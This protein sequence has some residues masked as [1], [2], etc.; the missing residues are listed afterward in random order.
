MT[1][2]NQI[3]ASTVELDKILAASTAK[4]SEGRIRADLREI[5]R[6]NDE[7]EDNDKMFK[8]IEKA[9]DQQIEE[10][11]ELGWKQCLSVATNAQALCELLGKQKSRCDEAVATLEEIGKQLCLQLREQDEEYVN[12]LKRSRKEI[13]FLEECI[14]NEHKILKAAFERELGKVENAF[15]SERKELLET[16]QNELEALVMER[17]TVEV[18]GLKLQ[19]DDVDTKRQEIKQAQRDEN[20][21]SL[22]TREKLE[23]ELRRLEIA[24]EDTRARQDLDTDKLEYDVRVLTELREDETVV[25]K[26]KKRIMM[27]KGALYDSLDIKQR[28]KKIEMKENNRLERDCERIEKQAAGMK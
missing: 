7:V 18:E 26:L 9:N 19:R 20:N 5:K 1:A 22:V 27:G 12:A 2:N 10:Q 28:D 8:L 14:I 4:I 17:D 6:R 11:V 15:K 23:S 16:K 3:H 24:L 25:T 21:A 13:E